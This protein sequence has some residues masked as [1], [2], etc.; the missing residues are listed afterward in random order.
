MVIFFF[1]SLFSFILYTSIFYIEDLIFLE[2]SAM[3]GENIP[4]CFLQCAR[5]I[6]SKIDSG[7][8]NLYFYIN[9]KYQE[10]QWINA[11]V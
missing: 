11:I 5:I 3:T 6:L 7:I 1:I 2:T 10:K 4:E 8:L 9:T